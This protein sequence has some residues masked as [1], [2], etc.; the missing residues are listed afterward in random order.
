MISPVLQQLAGNAL[1][2]ADPNN[3]LSSCLH[4]KPTIDSVTA[5]SS[6]KWKAKISTAAAMGPGLFGNTL[7]ACNVWRA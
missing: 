7:I 1:G 4:G 6:E 5:F 3:V 2:C